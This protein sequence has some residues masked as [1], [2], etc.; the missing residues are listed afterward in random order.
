MKRNIT[1]NFHGILYSIDEDAY[2]LLNNYTE[3]IKRYFSKKEDGDEIAN[4]IE[5][6]ISELLAEM[7]RS[8][9]NVV[10]I[11]N[12]QEIIKRVGSP[13]EVD[14]DMDSETRHDCETK[15]YS[16]M[17]E[18]LH[19]LGK[20]HLYRDTENSIAGGVLSGMSYFLGIDVV[21]L[22]L[23]AILLT[24]TYAIGFIVYLVLW[25][26]VPPAVTTEEKLKMHGKEVNISNI[27]DE[28]LQNSGSKREETEQQTS[29]NRGVAGINVVFNIVAVL[30]KC[31]IIFMFAV[32]AGSAS[33]LL[34]GAVITA[35]CM[36]LS[37][38]TSGSH[39]NI[40]EGVLVIFESLYNNP[41]FWVMLGIVVVSSVLVFVLVMLITKGLLSNKS[42][43]GRENEGCRGGRR[44]EWV[45][46][47]DFQGIRRVLG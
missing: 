10:T 24:F 44:D 29:E 34:I 5:C 6:R 4:D 17:H 18:Y 37:I 13:E 3:N 46:V 19:S 14:E 33:L 21:W 23:A 11:E 32:I 36:F 7:K 28:V 9:T 1:I 15:G 20:R 39:W 43:Y 40:P 22:R 41:I 26:I 30:L 35:L 12:V 8:G 31:L 16:H 25:I 27:S 45:E 2:Q 47:A 38:N 42:K